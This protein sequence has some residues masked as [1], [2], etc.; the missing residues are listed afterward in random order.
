MVPNYLCCDCPN[1][2]GTL[3]TSPR[4]IFLHNL[5][6]QLVSFSSNIPSFN[7]CRSA[8]EMKGKLARRERKEVRTEWELV[9]AILEPYWS[10]G[11]TRRNLN[12]Y[13]AFEKWSQKIF[14]PIALGSKPPLVTRIARTGLG[15]RLRKSLFRFT[16]SSISYLRAQTI[17]TS[18]LLIYA[19][20]TRVPPRDFAFGRNPC[21]SN[22]TKIYYILATYNP[23]F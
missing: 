17:E 6:E 18:S 23:S 22:K 21:G 3:F 1:I 11:S 8:T 16:S 10:P 9:S 5:L 15:T 2:L 13:Q 12:G 7:R 14:L 20:V 4:V 19:R